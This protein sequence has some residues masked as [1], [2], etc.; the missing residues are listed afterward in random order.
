[1]SDTIT[2]NGLVATTPRNIITGD[3]MS[4]TSFRLA[5]NQRRFD[6]GRN[7]WIDGDTNWYTVT[8]FRTLATNV[9]QS[10]NKGERIIVSGRIRIRDWE[11]DEGQTGISIEVDTDSICHDLAFGTSSFTRRSLVVAP[12]T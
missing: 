1:M 7:E 11:S 6:R 9:A 2:L 12:T 10:L 4:I 5:T 8:T 3:G